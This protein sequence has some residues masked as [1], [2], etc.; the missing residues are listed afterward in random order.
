MI[1]SVKKLLFSVIGLLSLAFYLICLYYSHAGVSW[2]WLWPMLTVFCLVRLIMLH[3]DIHLPKWLRRIYY[4]GAVLFLALFIAVE[5][6]IISAMTAEV[7][8]GLDYVITL[9]AA[10]RNGL[11]TSPLRFRIERTAEYLLENPDC[12][13]IASGG[14][15][16]NE[17]MSEAECIKQYLLDYGIDESRILTEDRSSDTEAN[18][19]NSYALIPEG[20]SVGIVSNSYH[21]YRAMR[22]AEL[23]GHET[24]GIAAV[25]LMPLGIHYTVREF[26]AVVEM[27]IMNLI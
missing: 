23:Q 27:E 2:L 8:S 20:S 26:F 18:I 1:N 9:G 17:S 15:G 16:V 6:L 4:A 11:P 19:R 24:V 12:V 22:I 7:P 10:V 13:A 14:Q 25:T 21:L 3:F 5:G